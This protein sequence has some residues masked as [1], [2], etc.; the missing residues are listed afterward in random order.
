MNPQRRALKKE[1]SD[2]K[3]FVKDFW[4]HEGICRAYGYGSSEA[5]CEFAIKKATDRILEIE[6]IL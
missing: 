5:K 3:R 1:L 4:W 2:L 6:K